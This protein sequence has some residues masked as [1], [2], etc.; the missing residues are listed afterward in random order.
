[1]TTASPARTGERD[2]LSVA[3]RTARGKAARSEAPRSSHA[4]WTPSADR[5]DPIALLERQAES[6]VPDLVPIRHGRMAS[7]PFAFFRGAAYVMAADL[8]ATPTSGL[9]V[10]L[11]GDAHL[12]NFGGFA[13]PD[14]RLLF[15]LN[16]FDETLPGPWEWDVKR[17]AASLSVAARAAY[18]DTRTRQGIVAAA[19]ARYRKA[20]RDFAGMRNLELWYSQL[21]VEEVL[22]NL[23]GRAD[24]A[25]LKRA[26][27]NVAKAQRKDN[28]QAFAKLTEWV[29]GAPRLIS[30]P[31]LLVPASELFDQ[32]G[33]EDRKA[34]DEGIRGLLR[35]YRNTLRR[36]LRSL[37]DEYEYRD[38]A[39]KVVGVGSAG[40]RAWIVLL[41]GRDDEDPLF[42]QVKEAQRSVLEEFLPRC[43]FTN[44]GRRVVEGQRLMQAAGDVLLGWIRAEGFDGV[45]RDFYVRQL[46]DWKLSAD[47]DAMDAQ[48]LELYGGLCGATLARAHARSGDR[49]AI[50]AYLGTSD[51]FDRAMA[52]FAERYA[53]QNERD[54]EKLVK[55]IETGRVQAEMGA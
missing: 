31:P 1:V 46:W 4:E 16:D 12:S 39:R 21:G 27:R 11:C 26:R 3:E 33:L 14:R 48:T 40:T 55:A 25:A 52:Q 36:D 23:A 7:S 19:V 54:Y 47:V 28:L 38:L 49:I 35:A 10:Q 53:D 22:S 20:M 2:A 34:L 44:Q 24:R 45:E 50:A 51:R 9:T 5:P 17:L 6:R 41:L 30:D 18:L 32:Y 8:A 37:L 13:G 29:D 42:L 15:D 43:V